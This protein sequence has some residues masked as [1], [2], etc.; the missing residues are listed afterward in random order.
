M[1]ER[2]IRARLGGRWRGVPVQDR[3]YV[4]LLG[5]VA[6]AIRLGL[7]LAYQ[8]VLA[9]DSH[10]YLDLAHRLAALHLHGSSGARTPGYPLLLL[11]LGYSPVATWCVQALLGVAA[12]LLVYALARRLGAGAQ[13][14]FAAGLLY[15]LDLEV[16]ALERTV[17]TETLTSFLLLV[18]AH[19]TV[20]I[21][22]ARRA[23]RATLG[24]LGLVLAYLCVVRP[25]QLA[26][27]VYV[28]VAVCIAIATAR[29]AGPR[30][31]RGALA[32]IIVPPV[33][34]LAAWAGVN[35]AT[36][37]VSTVSTVLGYNMIDHV[38]PYVQPEPGRDHGITVAYVAARQRRQ[39]RTSDLG[40][41]SADAQ[42]AMERA[43]GLDAAH[44]SGRLLGIAGGVIEHH[45]LQYLGSS[46]RQWPHFWLAPNYAY[47]FADGRPSAALRAIWGL[48]R[49]LVGVINLV[50]VLL[51]AADLVQRARRRTPLLSRAALVLAGVPLVGMIVATFL[52]YGDT[53]RYGY[54][55]FPLVLSVSFA[56]AALLRR[57]VRG[58][59]PRLRH[60]PRPSRISG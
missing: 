1:A 15:A 26:I 14:A 25:D 8:P 44:L 40:N 32:W 30:F 50:F 12:T 36:I 18:A 10:S 60:R 48:E 27:A 24:A 54:V 35:R 4:A 9:T 11:V 17:L 53:G 6:I 47:R 46:L 29:T 13:V 41:L 20:A 33:V 7:I 51:L 22:T 45:P 3:R 56:S 55:Y 49:V 16:L 57:T 39:A 19:L 52:A 43:S 31:G 28:A 59:A 23:R 37:G 5:G 2:G 21:V 58:W 34:V 42:P 38:A